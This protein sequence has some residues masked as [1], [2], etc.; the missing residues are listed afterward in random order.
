MSK[1]NVK[2]EM[3]RKII[4]MVMLIG[5]IY[6]VKKKTMNSGNSSM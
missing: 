3:P 5:S 4:L 2:N 6:R 1:L